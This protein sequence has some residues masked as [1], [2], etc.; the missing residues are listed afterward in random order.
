MINITSI[1]M[2]IER[3]NLESIKLCLHVSTLSGTLKKGEAF[4]TK[5]LAQRQPPERAK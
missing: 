2:I 4:S 1:G 5:I 3:M